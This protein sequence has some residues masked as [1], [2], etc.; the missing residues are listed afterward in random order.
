MPRRCSRICKTCTLFTSC[1]P[2]RARNAAQ[3]TSTRSSLLWNSTL[4]ARSRPSCPSLAMMRT[5][6]SRSACSRPMSA[7]P[8]TCWHRSSQRYSAFTKARRRKSSR[9]SRNSSPDPAYRFPEA[10][11][12]RR[13]ITRGS[14]RRSAAGPT[15]T[16]CKP[17]C[18]A[19]CN[20]R[21][22]ARTT[23]GISGSGT[24]RIRISPR[25]SGAT[26]IS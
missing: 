16:C 22:T 17:S 26:P 23:S 25:R 11:T 10:T 2:P 8:D 19:R 18:C 13:P 24:T 20:R 7:P 14:S 1:C 4:A 6:S 12:P 3:S 9:H 21:S 15:S 5:S